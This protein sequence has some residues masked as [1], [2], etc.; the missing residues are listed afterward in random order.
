[1]H[2][3]LLTDFTRLTTGIFTG[4]RAV[5]AFGPFIEVLDLD[6]L[7]RLGGLILLL[8]RESPKLDLLSEKF[9]KEQRD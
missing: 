5:K 4:W 2:T 3:C 9:E 7:I 8:L 1:M 6:L